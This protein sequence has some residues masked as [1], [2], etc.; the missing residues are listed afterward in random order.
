MKSYHRDTGDI[1]RD[2]F[3]EYKAMVEE[4]QTKYRLLSLKTFQE[5]ARTRQEHAEEIAALKND[6]GGHGQSSAQ[7]SRRERGEVRKPKFVSEKDLEWK[8][9]QIDAG[10][11]ADE[12]PPYHVLKKDPPLYDNLPDQIRQTTVDVWLLRC[13][14]V[15]ILED[16]Q[17]LE[18]HGQHASRLAHGLSWEPFQAQCAFYVGIALYQRGN[19]LEAYESFETAE[20]T[21]GYYIR[22]EDLLYWLRL[23]SKKLED[24][25][26]NDQSAKS[27][28]AV[29]NLTPLTSRATG[30]QNSSRLN[31]REIIS[32]SLSA[33]QAA[34]QSW[35]SDT[36]SSDHDGDSNTD[37][38]E[39]S[40]QHSDKTKKSQSSQS[41]EHATAEHQGHPTI[42]HE[43]PSRISSTQAI[44]S[45][46]PNDPPN[47]VP[48]QLLTH[49]RV[50]PAP[51]ILSA[52][53]VPA[54][55]RSP[56]RFDPG[57]RN[58]PPAKDTNS[59]LRTNLPG[60]P[61]SSSL[62]NSMTL[63]NDPA[64]KSPIS[65]LALDDSAHDSNKSTPS[66]GNKNKTADSNG[67]RDRKDEAKQTRE[68]RAAMRAGP[69]TEEQ[70]E[71]EERNWEY[72]QDQVREALHNR[73]ARRVE[74]LRSYGVEAH[75]ESDTDTETE[76]NPKTPSAVHDNDRASDLLIPSPVSPVPTPTP[77]SPTT[78]IHREYRR[79]RLFT[80][81]RSEIEAT[82]SAI[83]EVM[84][85]ASPRARTARSATTT[86]TTGRGEL[87]SAAVRGQ[88]R[89][90]RGR[91]SYPARVGGGD[92]GV[93]GD[94]HTERG[95]GM[96]RE[97]SIRWSEQGARKEEGGADRRGVGGDCKG[98]GGQG[99]EDE[100]KK[101][102]KDED[103]GDDDQAE[104]GK[105][106]DT[107][108]QAA[109]EEEERDELQ[110]RFEELIRATKAE[111]E[112]QRQ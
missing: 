37:H 6:N 106:G 1:P 28:E 29:Y 7:W 30:R 26:M 10:L 111:V 25:W 54:S 79:N 102:E 4:L 19:W 74:R 101:K 57:A 34:S 21:Q 73:R 108:G 59:N 18:S 45:D 93:H 88:R 33:S 49:R 36:G 72:D 14:T 48:S 23:C 110:R 8:S 3:N 60:T 100:K 83:Q 94:P 69:V 76:S 55:M 38:T 42:T 92:G 109:E 80:R 46:K 70:Q 86:T 107:N 95:R 12:D 78:L 17:T 89:Q 82:D 96:R 85:V 112:R 44:N 15:L 47:N 71:R 16:W 24:P 50:V 103:E 64:P 61:S 105:P 87:W 11:F 22:R 32:A 52:N 13:R 51:V 43:P 41:A 2:E 53:P 63:P 91:M 81:S 68:A 98:R 20:K 99:E 31:P 104:T 97:T 62:S 77:A 9:R 75:P 39:N 35:H 65:E 84:A 40:P 67:T 5:K 56:R 58:S 90:Q 66:K 27:Q